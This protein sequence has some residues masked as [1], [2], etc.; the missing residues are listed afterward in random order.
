MNRRGF[1]KF[2][3]GVGVGLVAAR[4]ERLFAA[5]HRA[6]F[7]DGEDCESLRAAI[8]ALFPA[9]VSHSR[10]AYEQFE[11]GR[12]DPMPS[13]RTYEDVPIYGFGVAT[14]IKTR[15]VEF[16]YYNGRQIQRVIHRTLALAYKVTG[17]DALNARLHK[18]LYRSMYQAF[19]LI[20]ER[21][22]NWK[23]VLIWRRTPVE[24]RG[25]IP[26]EGTEYSFGD[27]PDVVRLSIRA[28][29]RQTGWRERLGVSPW[30]DG[31]KPE[32]APTEFLS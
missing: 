19:T 31:D 21:P 32:G 5:P 13:P 25:R 4:P 26:K 14:P 20:A 16:I 27:G 7:Y 6:P 28:S 22:E 1:L 24:W 15:H 30:L 11:Y 29:L 17:D 18:A 9:G 12:G 23:A 10:K 2:L 8:E 3:G